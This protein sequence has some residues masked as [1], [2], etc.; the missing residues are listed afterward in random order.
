MDPGSSSDDD[1]DPPLMTHSSRLLAE[2]GR[3]AAAEPD[4]VDKWLREQASGD[5]VKRLH[6][7]CGELQSTGASPDAEQ[8]PT[9]RTASVTSELFQQWLSSSAAASP[10]MVSSSWEI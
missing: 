10:R 5:V 9:K 6:R 3:L 2:F 4:T 7:V 1:D 8:S